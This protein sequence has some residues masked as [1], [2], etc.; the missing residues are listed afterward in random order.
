M[1]K[2]SIRLSLKTLVSWCDDARI[3][4]GGHGF[5]KLHA[6][7]AH[8]R[9]SQLCNAFI[10]CFISEIEL[11]CLWWLYCY[12]L[13]SRFLAFHTMV[14]IFL[15]WTSASLTLPKLLNLHLNRISS[16][17]RSL[18]IWIALK[19]LKRNSVKQYFTVPDRTCLL[20]LKLALKVQQSVALGS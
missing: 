20:V 7:L 16:K 19:M 15:G 11:N 10:S 5:A 17:R 12:W 13:A 14:R 3:E 4:L 18:C 8:R 6:D 9:S 1:G 2:Y